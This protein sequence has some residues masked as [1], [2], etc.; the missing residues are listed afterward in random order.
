[1]CN[2]AVVGCGYWG[3]NLVRNLNSLAACNLKSVCD[4][5]AGR[6]SHMRDLICGLDEQIVQVRNQNAALLNRSR[7]FIDK[8]MQMLSR[9]GR[10]EGGYSPSGSSTGNG[11][12]VMVD[13]RV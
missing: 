6:L 11:T 4:T 9:V 5:D 12:R 2:I 13:R 7:E 1:M 3:P 8:S 10:S